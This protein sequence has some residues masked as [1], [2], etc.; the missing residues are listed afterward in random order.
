[1]SYSWPEVLSSIPIPRWILHKIDLP[2]LIAYI[3]R[4]IQFIK[5][6]WDSSVISSSNKRFQRIGGAAA[7]KPS[8]GVYHFKIG[9]DDEFEEEEEKGTWIPRLQ[10]IWKKMCRS[11]A[12]AALAY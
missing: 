4:D 3:A 7:R 1:M 6:I 8:N 10:R 2:T 12:G 9:S 5:I 11:A